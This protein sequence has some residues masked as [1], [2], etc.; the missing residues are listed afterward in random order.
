[1]KLW[2]SIVGFA[3]IIALIVGQNAAIA[4]DAT[5][6]AQNTAATIGQNLQGTINSAVTSTAST[7][8]VP[9]YAGQTSLDQSQYLSNPNGLGAAGVT[10]AASS[11]QYNLVT[12]VTTTVASTA[13]SL[14]V[15][16]AQTV[17]ANPNP[18]L[19]ISTSGSNGNCKA[20]TATPSA[21]A[22]TYY[23]SCQIGFTET[24][25]SF[26]CNVVWDDVF[27]TTSTYSCQTLTVNGI[28]T[29]TGA[30]GSTVAQKTNVGI[31]SSCGQLAATPGCTKT[32]S[33]TVAGAQTFGIKGAGAVYQPPIIEFPGY[34]VDAETDTYACSQAVSVSSVA[35]PAYTDWTA[36]DANGN[37]T[38]GSVVVTANAQQTGST[39]T[40]VSST[41]DDSACL[42]QAGQ[43]SCPAGS[44]LQAGQCVATQPA[45]ATLT[46]P[47]GWTLAGSTC[48]L[49][50]ISLASVSGLTCPANYTP[51]GTNCVSTE[52]AGI[53]GYTC[54]SGYTLNGTTCSQTLTQPAGVASYSCPTGFTLSGTVC[55]ESLSQPANVSYSCPAGYAL[56]GTT[57][58]ITNQ[59]AAVVS[60]TCPSG[61]TLNGDICQQQSSYTAAVAYT[62]PSTW[63]LT[64]SACTQ[65]S[66]YT[67]T[68]TYTCP[69]GWT[70]S[71]SSC[72][73]NT[74]YAPAIA[75]SCPGGWNLDGST[76]SQVSRY[77]ATITYSCGTGYSLSDSTCSQAV[78][79][80]PSIS[81]YCPS[82]WTVQGTSCVQNYTYSTSSPTC[83]AGGSLTTTKFTCH[84]VIWQTW[85]Q[86]NSGP[87]S[88]ENHGSSSDCGNI[89]GDASCSK[90]SS[91]ATPATA[92][93]DPGFVASQYYT[94]TYNYTCNGANS[95]AVAAQNTFCVAAGRG[96]SCSATAIPGIPYASG[97]VFD[98]GTCTVANSQTESSSYS[99][100]QGMTLQGQV[101][102]GTQTQTANANYSCADGSAPQNGTCTITS[103]Q[104]ASP[105]YSCPQGGTFDGSQC[106][107]TN[108][109][110]ATA[111]YSCP[112]G[113]VLNGSICTQTS[114]EAA[115][116]N[117]SC[118]QGGSLSGTTCDVT[119]EQ[120]ATAVYGCPTGSTLSG[121]MCLTASNQTAAPTYACPTNYQLQGTTC[122]LSESTNATPILACPT[123]YILGG[124][125][126]T[127]T[128]NVPGIAHFA[129][130]TGYTLNGS[131]CTS[132]V[133]ASASGYACPTGYTVSGT[134]CV[135][136]ATEPA[137]TVYSCPGGGQLQGTSCVTT[138]MPQSS[139]GL[140]CQTPSE[141]CSDAS[142]STRTEDGASVTHSCWQWTDSYQCGALAP[143]NN[144]ATLQANTACKFDHESCL[145][146]NCYDKSEVYLCTIPASGASQSVTTSCTGGIYCVDG[147]CNQIPQTASPD[148]QSALVAINSMGD[149]T[150]QLDPNALTI[151]GGTSTGCHKPV[152]GL[153]N[154]CAGKSSG[155]LSFAV[156]A[157]AL[158][159][160]GTALLGLVTQFLV[161]FLCS[162]SEMELDVQDRM[163]VC[164]YVGE[165]CSQ[166]LLFVCATLRHTYCCFQT[167]LARVIQEQ[168]REQLNKSWGT[169]DGLDCTGFTVA[170][171][172]QLD[173]SK[174]DFSEVY[175]DM[176]SAVSVP[177][178]LQTATQIQSQVQSYF[179][180]HAPGG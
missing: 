168:G 86:G 101:C 159:S 51:S 94:T 180:L 27:N 175:A 57:C 106:N 20:V 3:A 25:T 97:S 45:T 63:T 76:C 90:T 110:A 55:Y 108:S 104:A 93:N 116:A 111:N 74:S 6:N 38:T 124:S 135:V 42:A 151:F 165:Y 144:C 179:A 12:S 115:N 35:S 126:C 66:T 7:T 92:I 171:F 157:A 29:A 127:Q 77:P 58:T 54:P 140:T 177:S 148:F 43:I 170:E 128:L 71:G 167:K 70:V 103:T 163:G 4:Q 156:G 65:S 68:L 10:A 105:S 60:Y 22:S 23:D 75:Y 123:G 118:P 99:C 83:S 139:T 50:Q 16:A 114:S 40:L 14:N 166:K 52:A 119:N 136:S 85:V 69:S 62:C 102:T 172:A 26:S 34:S 113:G 129:C 67:A 122:V 47:S 46:C 160:G 5:A 173:L 169:P 158:A 81:Y 150:N 73:Q 13:S 133:A 96:T 33:S 2:R 152:F 131:T 138:T 145:D 117:Y 64:G 134:G 153:V 142:P 88:W 53:S 48:T 143:Q 174:M 87:G 112:S 155:L 98:G 11:A 164:H 162:Q 79:A 24:D 31:T 176:T 56:S 9:G 72:L 132:T 121:T 146:A 37:P 84:T 59:A 78:T 107:V 17:E 91:Q 147:S 80:T 18:Y 32:G 30:D 1:M 15:S 120:A 178:N 49:Q 41:K 89:A 141:V 137:N 8:N 19:G 21:A 100:P 154:C 109:E 61:W 125:T 95:D 161:T 44:V 28:N 36:V 149:A 130:A 39:S 82:G